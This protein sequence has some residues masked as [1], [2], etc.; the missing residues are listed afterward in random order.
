MKQ[1]KGYKEKFGKLTIIGLSD[2][3]YINPHS[4]KKNRKVICS[5]ECGGEI[6][7]ISGNVRHGCTNSC[8]CTRQEEW[9][10]PKYIN[11]KFGKLTIL[12]WGTTIRVKNRNKKWVRCLCDCGNICEKEQRS[13]VSYRVYSC[14]C[15]REFE[16]KAKELINTTVNKLTILSISDFVDEYNRI[17]YNTKCECGNESVIK[18]SELIGTNKQNRVRSGCG[19]CCNIKNGRFTSKI[20]IELH[21]MLGGEHNYYT[22]VVYNHNMRINVDIA[23]PEEKIAIEYDGS[24]WHDNPDSMIKD[25][26]QSMLLVNAGWK[27][28]RIKS[29]RDLPSLDE[30]NKR[31]ELLRSGERKLEV[32]YVDEVRACQK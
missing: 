1:P 28:L 21:K 20:N 15:C 18:V 32:I 7:A 12:G 9:G 27:L 10:K 22:D 11:K 17:Y 23:F 24:Y 3:V 16:D 5:C 14:G 4:G 6:H 25:M 2:Q 26:E 31:L 29:R 30:I 13:V 8:G 19:N